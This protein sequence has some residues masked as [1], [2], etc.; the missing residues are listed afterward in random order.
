[1]GGQVPKSILTN[2]CASMQRAIEM[3][4]VVWNSFTKDA[5]DR[6]WNDF[7]TKYGLKGNK[8]L[9]GNRDFNLNYFH[10]VTFWVKMCTDFGLCWLMFSIPVYLDHHFWY[11]MR[12]SE[13]M[14]VFLNKF[15]T[16]NSSLS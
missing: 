13:S 15:I 16:R 4:H 2:Q 6:N 9:S 11:G 10:A 8:W 7:I 12:S 14:H 3:S 1:M 5:F